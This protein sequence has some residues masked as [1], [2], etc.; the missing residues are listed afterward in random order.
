M[1]A[2]VPTDDDLRDTLAFEALMWAMARPG[3][4]TDLPTGLRDLVPALLD[5]E[6]RVMLDDPLLATL[7]MATGAS[8]VAAHH[9]DHAICLHPQACLSVMQALSAGSALY[10]DDGATL[11]VSAR[12][13]L[14]QAVR[15]TGPGIETEK[16]VRIG[17]L[18]KGFFELRAQKC[19][20]PEG[21]ELVIVDEQRLMAL[22]RSTKIEVL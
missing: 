14:G 1:L 21:I 2:P 15:L 16:I 17:E 5:R 13:G 8:L 20:Y 6:C 4:V 22:P 18:P 7:V 3:E 9:A 11:V 10:P 19:R 12:I